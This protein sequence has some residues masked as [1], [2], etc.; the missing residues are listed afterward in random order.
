MEL[1]E[2]SYKMRF[3]LVSEGGESPATWNRGK[4]NSRPR[5]LQVQNLSRSKRGMCRMQ[6]QTGV[7]SEQEACV[8]PSDVRR[9]TRS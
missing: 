5:K 2:S 3:G 9:G 8:I 6:R 1:W 7:A 4:E